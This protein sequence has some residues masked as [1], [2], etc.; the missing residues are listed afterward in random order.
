MTF[1]AVFAFYAL[2]WL[3]AIRIERRQL[4]MELV[5]V[6]AMT[7]KSGRRIADQRVRII[8]Q[9]RHFLTEDRTNDL[10][11]RRFCSRLAK[12]YN[13]PQRFQRSLEIHQAFEHHLDNSAKLHNASQLGS[14]ANLIFILTI[15][16]VPIAFFSAIVAIDVKN[17]IFVNGRELIKDFRIYSAFLV[18]VLF[19]LMPLITL[20]LL[21]K[22]R[23]W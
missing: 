14:V 5:P 4:F 23:Q 12:K 9:Q 2:G 6:S 21:D 20:R 16:S 1:G 15:L 17:D 8:D 11:L 18:G 22:F 19:T 13:L 10:E 7:L 3:S